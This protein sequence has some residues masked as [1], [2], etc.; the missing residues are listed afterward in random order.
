M[1]SP[2]HRS[3]KKDSPFSFQ[4]NQFIAAALSIVL[5]IF[6]AAVLSILNKVETLADK[7]KTQTDQLTNKFDETTDKITN[8]TANSLDT[9][10]GLQ[11]KLNQLQ[12]GYMSDQLNLRQEL[13]DTDDKANDAQKTASQAKHKKPDVKTY[14]SPVPSPEPTK[15]PTALD[16]LCGLGICGQK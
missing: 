12:S 13:S 10:E 1:V 2:S 8:T 14:P 11:K 16:G 7:T 4:K 9:V 3:E 15:T 6:S 5:T